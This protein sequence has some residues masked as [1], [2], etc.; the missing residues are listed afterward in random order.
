MNLLITRPI[1]ESNETAALI[2]AETSHKL[3]ISPLLE[4]KFLIKTLALNGDENIII[5]SAN[6]VDALAKNHPS[7]NFKLNL[8]GD[9]SYQKA[10]ALGYINVNIGEKSKL[11]SNPNNLINFICNN[12]KVETIFHHI[13]S[14]SANREIEKILTSN[15]YIYKRHELYKIKEKILPPDIIADIS[16]GKIMGVMLFSSK[17]AEVMLKEFEKQ[18]LE[19]YYPDKININ[20]FIELLRHHG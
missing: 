20:S 8:I 16:S 9:A 7:K 14:I 10:Q 5:T 17:T 3:F 11:D 6:G 2:E 18:N 1:A 4:T 19:I 13:T 12:Y 15:G